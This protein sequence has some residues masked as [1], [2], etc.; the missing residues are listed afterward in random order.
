MYKLKVLL[1]GLCLSGI[2][3]H[4][5]GYRTIGK[6]KFRIID[7]TGFYLYR[8]NKLVQGEKI[9]RPQDVYYFSTGPEAPMLKLTLDNLEKTF[10]GNARFRYAL[11]AHF[12]SDR[13]L[14]AYDPWLK[15]YKLKVLYSQSYH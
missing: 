1:T 8:I 5:Q 3:T 13:Q 2:V 14:I 15:T 12:H 6:E 10:A 7:T 11:E 9:A 4:G